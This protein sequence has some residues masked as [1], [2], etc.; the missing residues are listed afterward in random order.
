MYRN[1]TNV[2]AGTKLHE[3]IYPIL[4]SNLKLALLVNF[5]KFILLLTETLKLIVC[6]V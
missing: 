1:N 5:L 4:L 3:K 6:T 2:T